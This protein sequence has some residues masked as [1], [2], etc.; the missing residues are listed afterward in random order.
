MLLLISLAL[1]L[2]EAIYEGLADRGQKTIAGALE[3]L[4]RAATLTAVYAWFAGFMPIVTVAYFG[5]A[6]AGFILLR[7][8]IFDFAYNL[9]V[10]LPMFYVGSTKVYDK[11]MTWFLEKT[12]WPPEYFLGWIKFLLGLVAVAWLLRQAVG[13]F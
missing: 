9:T 2:L 1:I 4:Y 3:F 7:F 10:G 12:N 5:Y 13:I 8:A 11:A 6:I